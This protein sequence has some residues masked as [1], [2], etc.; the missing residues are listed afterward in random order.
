MLQ[1]WLS[2]SH[3]TLPTSPTVRDQTH[4][5]NQS[6]LIGA[7]NEARERKAG[8]SMEDMLQVF[9]TAA[10]ADAADITDPA[11]LEF[12]TQQALPGAS[13]ADANPAEAGGGAWGINNGMGGPSEALPPPQ[14]QPQ[15]VSDDQ[16][17][18]ANQARQQLAINDERHRKSYDTP[19][20][21]A[22][23]AENNNLLSL[24]MLDKT[25][26]EL[27][28]VGLMQD[29][30]GVISKMPP[31]SGDPNMTA[32]AIGITPP[33]QQPGAAAASAPTGQPPTT[34]STPENRIDS[35]GKY[36]VAEKPAADPQETMAKSVRKMLQNKNHPFWQT[37]TG[38]HM[39][40][41]IDNFRAGL[42]IFEQMAGFDE[43]KGEASFFAKENYK[44]ALSEQAKENDAIRKRNEELRLEEEKRKNY[45]QVPIKVETENGVEEK[46]FNFLMTQEE[47]DAAL[48]PIKE[49]VDD[50]PK[51]KRM[52][53][54]LNFSLA[55]TEIIRRM[56]ENGR[57]EN[58]QWSIP[59]QEAVEILQREGV[60]KHNIQAI[61]DNAQA[62]NGQYT[63]ESLANSVDFIGLNA[64]A[65]YNLNILQ[66]KSG[67]ASF[68]TV[69]SAK[70][71]VES[72]KQFNSGLLDDATNFLAR[73]ITGGINIENL[74][75]LS[76]SLQKV[77]GGTRGTAETLNGRAFDRL[78]RSK[79]GRFQDTYGKEAMAELNGNPE[80]VNQI[81]DAYF[82]VEDTI[83]NFN[84]RQSSKPAQQPKLQTGKP[85]DA[86]SVAG[87]E[88]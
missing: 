63:L 59:I 75:S 49:E 77:R 85:A 20:L 14:A 25:D 6:R 79:R 12:L 54:F 18:M 33:P 22:I 43:S 76:E 17:A 29:D 13:E 30:N 34:Q 44:H 4:I 10:A 61:V 38:Q 45:I 65:M 32:R 37:K 70:D 71:I 24:A 9:T 57:G 52:E 51:L 73:G 35:G 19:T 84:P 42:K 46:P 78:Y 36:A 40:A 83:F 64:A 47:A 27:A 21:D 15:Q 56:D 55:Q 60:S 66:S 8:L 23:A 31:T 48:E 5:L 81:M 72:M 39:L 74:L 87:G 58:H 16:I 86:A 53:D 41:D 80:F 82:G 3:S 67:A 7:N 11:E 1:P 26:E 88:L 62:H 50:A 28:A 2:P 69:I 68:A